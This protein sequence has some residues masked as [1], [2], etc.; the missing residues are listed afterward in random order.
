METGNSTNAQPCPDEFE[1]LPLDKNM[2]IYLSEGESFQ[3]LNSFDF[4]PEDR[5]TILKH[6][7]E[8]ISLPDMLTPKSSNK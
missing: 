7:E 6:R 2:D 4:A 1:A 5:K 3:D 8:A